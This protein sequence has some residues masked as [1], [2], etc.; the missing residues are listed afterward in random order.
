MTHIRGVCKALSPRGTAGPAAARHHPCCGKAAKHRSCLI[1]PA[2]SEGISC[3]SHYRPAGEGEHQ[4]SSPASE[5]RAC[6]ATLLPGELP[7][8]PVLQRRGEPCLPPPRAALRRPLI[9]PPLMLILEVVHRSSLI[10]YPG[11][12][13]F[14]ASEKEAGDSIRISHVVREHC[15]HQKAAG[16][17]HQV[18]G[19]GLSLSPRSGFY[20]WVLP[21]PLASAPRHCPPAHTPIMCYGHSQLLTPLLCHTNA[22][23]CATC[24]NS[25]PGASPKCTPRALDAIGVWAP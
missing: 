15:Q 20:L 13:S 11:G 24:T 21:G 17:A 6:Q 7:C 25:P 19:G 1:C 3:L 8:H 23:T 22:C 10:C 18:L 4:L 2:A 16:C 9:L 5:G 14:R 12:V